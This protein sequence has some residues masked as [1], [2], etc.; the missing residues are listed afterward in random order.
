MR[1][2]SREDVL[3]MK[4]FLTVGDLLKFIEENQIPVTAPVMIQRVED[5]YY[6]N[7]DWGVYLKK[8]E[9][10]RNSERMNQLMN[11]EIDRRLRG[12][13]PNF[14]KIENPAKYIVDNDESS[15][16]QYHPA[17]SGCRYGDDTDMLFIDL[18]Y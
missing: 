13:E 12:E 6:E 7:H 4:H 3:E 17:W 10:Y 16:E 2:L 14:P 9:H 5:V 8:G 1:T 18:H 11:E 15:M